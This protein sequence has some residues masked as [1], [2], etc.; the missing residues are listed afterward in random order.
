MNNALL[1]RCKLVVLSQ[2]TVENIVKILK[3]AVG[4]LNGRQLSED[5]NE[6]D[7][8]DFRYFSTFFFLYFVFKANKK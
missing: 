4:R 5:E 6:K 1:S 2:L 7:Q 3:N 8:S